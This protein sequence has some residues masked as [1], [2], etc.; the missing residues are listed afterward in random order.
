MSYSG[1][2]EEKRQPQPSLMKDEIFK[3]IDDMLDLEI[4]EPIEKD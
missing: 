4:L 2:K 1:K 3:T